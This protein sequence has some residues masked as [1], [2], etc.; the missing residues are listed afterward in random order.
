[1]CFDYHLYF[2]ENANIINSYKE[3]LSKIETLTDVS[4]ELLITMLDGY[5]FNHEN[6]I[7]PLQHRPIEDL[8]F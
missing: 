1:M 7:I 2:N 3:I 8:P 5:N 4:K 6:I